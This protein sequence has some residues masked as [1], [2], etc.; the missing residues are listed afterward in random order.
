MTERKDD[1]KQPQMHNIPVAQRKPVE[2]YRVLPTV[3][4]ISAKSSHYVMIDGLQKTI[5]VTDNSVDVV[6]TA[7]GHARSQTTS[8]R[9]DLGIFVDGKPVGIDGYKGAA[10][11][12][13]AERNGMGLTHTTTWAPIVSFASISLPKRKEDYVIDCRVKNGAN[14]N[15]AAHVN[16]TAMLIQVFKPHQIIEWID[17]DLNDN[18]TYF[19]K[20]LEYK[21][22]IK[23]TTTAYAITVEKENLWFF[24][25]DSKPGIKS[26][27]YTDKR[28]FDDQYFITR[29]QCCVRKSK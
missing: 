18:K 24:Y 6:I 22:E 13:N 16:G 14:N 15:Q 1:E 4:G 7:H 5:K 17:I 8:A 27:K 9:A 20:D 21:I 23:A 3:H 2:V 26:V 25:S 12:S 19:N 28:S 10:G 11:W 29:I